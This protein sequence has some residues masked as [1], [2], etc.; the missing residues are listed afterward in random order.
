MFLLLMG[1]GNYAILVVYRQIISALI[2][3]RRWA[4]KKITSGSTL[5]LHIELLR[6][7]LI[8]HVLSPFLACSTYLLLYAC[9]LIADVGLVQ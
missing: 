4:L 3:L 8:F 1:H 5:L 2:N 9:L 7:L 6:F